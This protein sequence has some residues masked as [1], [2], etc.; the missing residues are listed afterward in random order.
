MD[1][2]TGIDYFIGQSIHSLIAIVKDYIDVT[3]EN[4]EAR[5]KAVKNRK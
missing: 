2:G 5:R 1:M 4:A 3:N